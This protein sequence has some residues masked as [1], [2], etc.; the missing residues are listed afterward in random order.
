M[1][2]P[3]APSTTG[4]AVGWP[5]FPISS[6]KFP[7]TYKH[8]SDLL[9][10][11]TYGTGEV[12]VTRLYDDLDRLTNISTVASGQT[13]NA[14]SYTLDATGRRTERRDAD[15]AKLDWDYDFFDQLTSAA[16]TNSPNGAADAAYRYQYQYDLVGNRLQE[17]RGPDG[18]PLSRQLTLDGSHNN[19]NQLTTRD[20]SGKLPIHGSVD[21]P[22]T[23]LRRPRHHQRTTL[24]E[25]H[26]LAGRGHPRSRQQPG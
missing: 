14:F 23:I 10:K 26:Q 24:L 3:T 22:D 1:T 5:K 2:P 8:N 19:L 13:V 18:D 11:T 20:W 21:D 15:G 7:I 12:V 25:R 9:W 6:F 17:K 16:R 4:I